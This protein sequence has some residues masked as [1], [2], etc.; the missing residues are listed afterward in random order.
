MRRNLGNT[1]SE[2]DLAIPTLRL[3]YEA[4][5]GFLT[6]A[7]L[8]AALTEEFRPTGRDAEMIDNRRDTHFSQKVRNMISHRNHN[9]IAEGLANYRSNPGGLVI[10]TAGRVRVQGLTPSNT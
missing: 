8:I 4:P 5:G 3:L 9:F 2:P 1:I 7:Q 10:T 6:T